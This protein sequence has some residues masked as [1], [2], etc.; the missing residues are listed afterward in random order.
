MAMKQTQ[1]KLF[2]YSDA[3]LDFSSGSMNLFPDRFKKILSLGYNVQTVSSVAVAGNQVTFTYGGAHGYAQDRVLKIDAGVLASINNGEFW[4]DSVTTN[5]VTF[6]LDDAPS[7]IAA[8][9]STKVAP[10]GWDLVYEAAPIYIY[11]FKALDESDLFLRLCFQVTTGDR[12]CIAVCIGKS[13]DLIAG[14]IT[15]P[16]SIESTRSI[17]SLRSVCPKW[18]FSPSGSSSNINYTYEQGFSNYGRGMIVGSKY[19]VAIMGNRY[20]QADQKYFNAIL[21]AS[22]IQTDAD[23]QYP[24][25]WCYNS[26]AS[27]SS[28]AFSDANIFVGYLGKT[29]VLCNQRDRNYMFYYYVVSNQ[30]PSHIENFNTIPAEPIQIFEYESWQPIGYISAPV[31]FLNYTT[32]GKKPA[33]ESAVN[34]IAVADTLDNL[35]I[36]HIPWAL[37]SSIVHATY[38]VAGVEEVKIV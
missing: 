38:L 7:A 5:T 34:P 6:T 15:D 27:N 30:L 10:L 14:I 17:K 8:G 31:W 11:K 1:T 2:D 28:V 13:A 32:S 25:L 37:T 3:G 16:S 36:R 12:N 26:S 19:H 9:F 4:V 29:R 21:P 18:E 35:M 24:M 23:L 20:N 22:I 33:I